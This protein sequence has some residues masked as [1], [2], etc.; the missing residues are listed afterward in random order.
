M[1]T[2][3]SLNVSWTVNT[4]VSEGG[5]QG[6]GIDLAE[7]NGVYWRSLIIM[8]LKRHKLYYGWWLQVQSDF[9]SD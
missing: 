2:E 4:E 3:S 9:T 7:V 6:S 5:Y 1:K 8:N